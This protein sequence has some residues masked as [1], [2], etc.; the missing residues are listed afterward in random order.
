MAVI[1]IGS[2]GN[3][4]WGLDSIFPNRKRYTRR[5]RTR[6]NGSDGGSAETLFAQT[7]VVIAW[8]ALWGP[9]GR[10]IKGAS[11]RLERKTFAQLAKVPARIRW[12]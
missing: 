6:S 2:S 8:V 12:E 9:A 5:C 3:S 1:S 11:Y 4:I 7:F 10:F